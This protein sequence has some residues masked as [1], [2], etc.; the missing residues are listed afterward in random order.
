[1]TQ[2]ASIILAG[3]GKNNITL[4]WSEALRICPAKERRCHFRLKLLKLEFNA[5]IKVYHQHLLSRTIGPLCTAAAL[6][7]I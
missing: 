7:L 2:K 3:P 6:Y 1:M 5:A 4:W